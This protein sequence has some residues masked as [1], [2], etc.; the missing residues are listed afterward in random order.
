MDQLTVW[1]QRRVRLTR[2]AGKHA[3]GV[4]IAPSALTDFT[5]LFS[6]PGGGGGSI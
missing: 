1:L 6:E 5:P 3:G 2:N 4:V